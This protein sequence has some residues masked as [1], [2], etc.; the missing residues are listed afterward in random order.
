[1]IRTK[2]KENEITKLI[3]MVQVGLKNNIFIAHPP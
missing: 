3:W 2:R 1:M